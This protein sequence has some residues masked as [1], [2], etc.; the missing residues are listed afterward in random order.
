MDPDHYKM[1]GVWQQV[2]ARCAM[3][4][5]MHV[6]TIPCSSADTPHLRV[7]PVCIP[8]TTR[9]VGYD[10]RVCGV[11][12]QV[13][14]RCAMST[15]M[16]ATFG[17][18]TALLVTL[19]YTKMTTGKAMWDL[20]MSTNGAL[21]GMVVRR[22]N[23]NTLTN[24]YMDLAQN[25]CCNAVQNVHTTFC[26]VVGAMHTSLP[27]VPCQAHRTQCSFDCIASRL[28][29]DHAVLDAASAWLACSLFCQVLTLPTQH[30]YAGHQYTVLCKVLLC[31]CR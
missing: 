28:T 16:G 29:V 26:Y 31:F 17:G 6:R 30:I 4:M 5:Q 23:H 13:V 19:V 1:C 21:T 3:S 27:L 14:A 8:T 24:V 22:P 20:I 25:N 9:F 10:N 18:C 7:K 2:V 11:R 15:T 12:Q